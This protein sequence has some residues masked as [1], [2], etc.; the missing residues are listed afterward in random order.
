MLQ[1]LLVVFVAHASVVVDVVVAAVA[2]PMG[3]RMLNDARVG[4][5]DYADGVDASNE[6]VRKA[7]S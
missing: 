1:L 3:T 2:A 4:V 7:K 5:D 6:V